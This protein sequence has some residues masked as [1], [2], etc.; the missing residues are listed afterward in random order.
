MTYTQTASE[1]E[2]TQ[3]NHY[4]PQYHLTLS[5]THN[6][7]VAKNLFYFRLKPQNHPM[8]R[9][10]DD[11]IDENNAVAMEKQLIRKLTTFKDNL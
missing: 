10:T 6:H 11:D 2:Q 8:R 5:L 3:S 1:E 9:T 7:S 4:Q